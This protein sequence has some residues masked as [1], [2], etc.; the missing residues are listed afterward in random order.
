MSSFSGK[1]LD[2]AATDRQPPTLIDLGHWLTDLRSRASD[3]LVK[4]V[5]AGDPEADPADV[6]EDIR[7]MLW[8]FFRE[9]EIEAQRILN[10]TVPAQ[11]GR[12]FVDRG[13]FNECLAFL[14]RLSDSSEWRF[15]YGPEEFQTP[16]DEDDLYPL[17]DEAS[18]QYRILLSPRT[19]RY[20]CG[21]YEVQG[22]QYRKVFATDTGRVLPTNGRIISEE[23]LMEVYVWG[24]L[25]AEAAA[26][27]GFIPPDPDERYVDDDN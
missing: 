2:S 16:R 10:L 1:K 20:G 8:P 9:I 13:H 11:G 4:D 19:Q 24:R 17:Y 7:E 3:A 6:H 14:A 26:R 18:C 25:D 22:P 23:D 12:Q 27:R 21:I 5:L 15:L